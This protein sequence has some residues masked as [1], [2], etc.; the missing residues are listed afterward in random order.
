VYARYPELLAEMYAYSMAAAHEEL[1]HFTMAQY[2][3]SNTYMDE[4][5]WPWI[6]SLGTEVCE[7]PDINGVY[8]A[9]KPMPTFLHYC[10]FFRAA[11][12]GFQKRRVRKPIFDCDKPIMLEL[13][14]DLGKARFKNRDGDVMK[15][16]KQQARRNA[17]ALCTI[18][19]SINSMLKHYKSKMCP[20]GSFVNLNGSINVVARDYWN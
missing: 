7:P 20:P 15:M 19:N 18:H 13:P 12:I 2:M 14:R 17:F 11:D 6:D 9:G 16:S 8:Y 10:Q 1:P 4:E 3:I 5:G